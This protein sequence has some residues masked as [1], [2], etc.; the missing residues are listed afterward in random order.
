MTCTYDI[1]D[2]IR[3]S[4]TFENLSN[5]LVDPTSVVLKIKLPSGS[6]ST[7]TYPADAA[8]ERASEGVYQSDV[9]ITEA[10]TWSYRFQ[11]TGAVK[12]AV[13]SYFYVR[14]SSF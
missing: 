10:G 9:E 5:A 11:G 6:I 1:G 4:V 8:I 14:T 3:L 13:E 12:A 2:L 7:L